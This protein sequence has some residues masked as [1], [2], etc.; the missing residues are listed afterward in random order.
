MSVPGAKKYRQNGLVVIGVHTPE[1]SFKHNVDNVQR[2]ANAMQVE[3]PIALD[4]DY[5]MWNAFSNQ[6]WPALYF[7]DSSGRIRHHQFG[8][9]AYDNSERVIQQLLTRAGL[10]G[11]DQELVTVELQGLEVGADWD[12]VKSPETYLGS[13]RSSHARSGTQLRL[14]QW[15]LA[16][17]W[18]VE[19][20]RVVLDEPNGRIAFQ[21]HAR[22]L[23]LVMGPLAGVTSIPFRVLIDGQTP[24]AAHGTDVDEDGNGT[25]AQQRVYQLIRQPVPI[26]ERRFEIQFLEPGAAAYDFTF[27]QHGLADE[28]TESTRARSRHQLGCGGVVVHCTDGC[29]LDCH[30]LKGQLCL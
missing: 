19:N 11:F 24:G 5:A 15:A 28:L 10:D 14:N 27:G 8:E 21:F 12:N 3:Y 17:N 1:F 22:D 16:G 9:G 7:A 6:Y 29:V 23:N 25:L 4:N 2:A 20:E 26:A 13:D 30:G 18:T